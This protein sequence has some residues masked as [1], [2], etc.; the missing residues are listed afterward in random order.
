MSHPSNMM[1]VMRDRQTDKLREAS[2]RKI[3]SRPSQTWSRVRALFGAER[4]S[5]ERGPVCEFLLPATECRAQFC[6]V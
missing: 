4:R 1:M 5:D 6:C 3:S 2:R